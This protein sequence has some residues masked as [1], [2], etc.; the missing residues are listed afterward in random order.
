MWRRAKRR[1]SIYAP[2][3][4]IRPH[5]PW[6]LRWSL[7]LP[8]VLGAGFLIWFAYIS[9]LQFAG[10]SRSETEEEINQLRGKVSKLEAENTQL[11][12]Q[13]VNYERQMQ[14][15]Q[16][17]SQETVRQMKV[18]ND[19]NA[20]LQEDLAF[21]QSLT[22]T[23]AKEGDLAV[24]RLRVE[25]DNLPGEFHVKMLLVQGGQRA[26]EFVGH[27]QIVA[28]MTQN[29]QKITKLF[30]QVNTPNTL[31]QL[32]FKYYQRV[33]QSIQLPQDAHLESVQVRVFEQGEREPKIRQNVSVS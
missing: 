32:K 19:Q 1:F 30:P 24:H 16:G 7:V 33:E 20:K 2:K 8:F 21:F 18:L 31:F 10:F 17:S 22:A 29:G 12:S 4:S 13:V 3:V 9:G 26:K 23:N 6:Y 5:I 15:A 14:M 28:T 27:C 11:N 25:R